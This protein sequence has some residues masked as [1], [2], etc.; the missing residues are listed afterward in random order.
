MDRNYDSGPRRERGGYGR[1]G[2]GNRISG[3]DGGRF[4]GGRNDRVG[5][6]WNS[7]PNEERDQFGGGGNRFGDRFGSRGGRSRGGDRG[8]RFGGSDRGNRFG[9]GRGA[10]I[11]RSSNEFGNE[12]DTSAS[13]MGGGRGGA[14][15]N[16]RGRGGGGDRGARQRRESRWGGDNQSRDDGGA[17]P[18]PLIVGNNFRSPPPG[19][20]Q[21][22]VPMNF[23]NQFQQSVNG[24]G[25]QPQIGMH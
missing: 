4:G 10:G 16:E 7:A 8:N 15:N 5:N 11:G 20:I 6:S 12:A 25:Y 21:Q 19:Y 17:R 14:Y 9:D 1:G 23:G 3:G 24:G 18:A 2:R 22:T 13:Y